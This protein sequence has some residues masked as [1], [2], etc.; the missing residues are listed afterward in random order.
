[1]RPI[2]LIPRLTAFLVMVT[3]ARSTGRV[4]L[5]LAVALVVFG[6][7]R[8]ARNGWFWLGVGVVIC[9]WNLFDWATIDNHIVLSGYWYLALGASLLSDDPERQMSI[10][11]RILI[12]LVMAAA[13][14]R[15]VT[16]P[17][18]I[19]GD[20][21]VFTL[22]VDPRFEPAASLVG[23]VAHP[24]LNRA[25]MGSLP[26]SILPTSASGIRPLA[27]ALTW[28]ALIIEPAVAAFTLLPAATWRKAGQISLLAF[29]VVT[30]LLV[31]VVA[32]GA[33]LIVMG[34]ASAA[35]DRSR[36]RWALGF[37]VLAVWGYLWQGATL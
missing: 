2:V 20:F 37:I 25:A 13:V 1:L 15:K 36:A 7:D 10:Q 32:F 26:N 33:G 17:E 31:P 12:G 23:G 21:F 22:L 14:V 24:S 4:L 30:Y 9:T 19:N 11:A 29:M 35:T 28:G 8:L 6:F 34:A 18:F 3:A 27:L 5:G 16:N